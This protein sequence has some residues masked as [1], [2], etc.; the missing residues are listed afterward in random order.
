MG[1]SVVY[2]LYPFDHHRLNAKR[3]SNSAREIHKRLPELHRYRLAD[4][5]F[6]NGSRTS[7]ASNWAF[8]HGKRSA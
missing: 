8:E 7:Q 5:V 3:I 4:E 1:L 6:P 2:Y